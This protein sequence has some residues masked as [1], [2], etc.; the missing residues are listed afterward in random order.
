MAS[1]LSAP[2]LAQ[3][4]LSR[5]QRV[6]TWLQN[7][8]GRQRLLVAAGFGAASALAFGPFF[9]WPV[10]FVSFSALVWLLDGTVG[11]RQAALVAWAFGFGY[12]LIGLHWVGFAFV[13]DVER[14]GWL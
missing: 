7:V 5:V 12:F 2:L 4:L 14:H 8:R 1:S 9:L 10:L 13:V 11:W 6:A 3:N